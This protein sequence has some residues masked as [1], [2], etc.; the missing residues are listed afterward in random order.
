MVTME[1]TGDED[2]D[3]RNIQQE[4]IGGVKDADNINVYKR[5]AGVS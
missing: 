5:Y 4:R 2:A 3:R 1:T